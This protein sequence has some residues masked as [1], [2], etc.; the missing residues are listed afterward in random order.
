MLRVASVLL[1]LQV[2]LLFRQGEDD[3]VT[4]LEKLS[5]NYGPDYEGDVDALWPLLSECLDA[6]RSDAIPMLQAIAS[7]LDA[8]ALNRWRDGLLD[9]AASAGVIQCLHMVWFLQSDDRIS[10]FDKLL[11]NRLNQPVLA[12]GALMMLARSPRKEKIEEFAA[13]CAEMYD[14]FPIAAGGRDLLY[15]VQSGGNLHGIV[16]SIAEGI[17]QLGDPE[18][19]VSA[20]VTLAARGSDWMDGDAV[21][22]LSVKR[23][24][25][26]PRAFNPGRQYCDASVYWARRELDMWASR[27][28]ELVGRLAAESPLHFELPR[29]G[30]GV[31]IDVA[32]VMAPRARRILRS[33]LPA[34][35]VEVFDRYSE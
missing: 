4:Q 34:E 19:Q 9:D 33:S 35:A 18:A 10:Y 2:V 8:V 13:I 23:L 28:A 6:K 27:D 1:L 5:G 16:C 29:E 22:E 24:L 3:V 14:R 17:E 7:K 21:K 20:L 11:E 30:D 25:R 15:Y 12:G 31:L 26:V 32:D